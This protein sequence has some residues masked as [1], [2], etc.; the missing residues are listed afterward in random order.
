MMEASGLTAGWAAWTD[1]T[2]SALSCESANARGLP[3]AKNSRF[4]LA[5][6]ASSSRSPPSLARSGL[7][8]LTRF[9][10]GS[11]LSSRP[12]ASRSLPVD[13]WPRVR[14][15]AGRCL[16]SAGALAEAL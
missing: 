13:S 1:C 4:T 15:G 8:S 16:K 7:S 9:L 12:L 2:L 10:N 14:P 6:T 5:S 11:P 3:S